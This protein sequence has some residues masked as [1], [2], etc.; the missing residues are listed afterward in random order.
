MTE[1][2]LAAQGEQGRAFL[3]GLLD[4]LGLDG[5][6]AVRDVDEDTIEVTVTG[7]DL[8]VLIGGKG[9]TLA[10]VQDLTRSAVQR[11]TGGR[12]GRLLV[13]I[14]GYR[15][16][17]REALGRFTSSVAQEVL[18]SG[19]AT[20]LEPMSAAD[21]KVVHDVVNDIDGVVTTSEGEE[22]RRRVVILPG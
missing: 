3:E 22:P 14:S 1:A 10:A 7:P 21:R 17:R 19:T 2:S 20:A 6:V 18:T 4:R 9:A 15:E 12:E 13:D 16:K 11:R 5:A 8:G